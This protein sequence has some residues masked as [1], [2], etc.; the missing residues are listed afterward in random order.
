M[1]QKALVACRNGDSV[2][3][4][5]LGTVKY[6]FVLWSHLSMHMLKLDLC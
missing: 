1:L 4:Y 5:N 3:M 6:C 2:D